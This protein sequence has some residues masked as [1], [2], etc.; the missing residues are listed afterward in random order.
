MSLLFFDL[1]TFYI[2]QLFI[3]LDM[4]NFN[5]YDKQEKNIPQIY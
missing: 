1:S 3:L 5:F 4:L 2:I